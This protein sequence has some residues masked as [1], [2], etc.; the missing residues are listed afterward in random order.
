MSMNDIKRNRSDFSPYVPVYPCVSI[1]G[2]HRDDMHYATQ[3]S[4]VIIGCIIC[5]CMFITCNDSIALITHGSELMNIIVDYL[6]YAIHR[7]RIRFIEFTDNHKRTPY[8]INRGRSDAC[9]TG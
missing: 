7:R 1:W 4:P 2:Y 9:C 6:A 5:C 3:Y 8:G